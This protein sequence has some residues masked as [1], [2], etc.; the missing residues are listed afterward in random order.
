M[1]GGR[2]LPRG[3]R[4]FKGCEVEKGDQGGWKIEEDRGRGGGDGEGE[5]EEMNPERKQRPEQTGWYRRSQ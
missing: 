1:K 3:K 2:A 5:G 4:K